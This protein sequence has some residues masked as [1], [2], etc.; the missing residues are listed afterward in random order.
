MESILS[1]SAVFEGFANLHHENKE[2]TPP[3]LLKKLKKSL[4]KTSSNL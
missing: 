2:T 1:K 4:V 3:L